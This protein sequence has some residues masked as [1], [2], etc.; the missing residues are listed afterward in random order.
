[1]LAPRKG[2][3]EQRGGAIVPSVR[4]IDNL[5]LGGQN[6]CV[7]TT[8]AHRPTDVD[9]LVAQTGAVGCKY[10]NEAISGWPSDYK[11]AYK[12]VPG[13]PWQNDSSF[14]HSGLL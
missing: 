6:S 1:M 11:S 9:M 5:L 10:G 4:N 2:I 8:F 13:V 3:W 14:E 7:G 12:Q